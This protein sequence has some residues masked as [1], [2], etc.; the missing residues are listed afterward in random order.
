MQ[1]D[2]IDTAPREKVD[3]SRSPLTSARRRSHLPEQ[4]H[5][6]KNVCNAKGL[7]LFPRSNETVTFT[8][9]AVCL[10]KSRR[11]V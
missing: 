2:I 1:I 10:A 5:A 7:N 9:F 11:L 6:G 3:V 4:S 8:R